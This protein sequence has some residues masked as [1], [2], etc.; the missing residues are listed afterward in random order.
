[1]AGFRVREAASRILPAIFLALF[2]VPR[3]LAA[4]EI[5]PGKIPADIMTE[6]LRA[7]NAPQPAAARACPV[8]F[9]ALSGWAGDDHAAAFFAFL[10]TCAPALDGKPAL[11]DALPPPDALRAACLAARNLAM[12]SARDARVFFERYFAAFDIRPETTE[13][14]PGTGFLT[15][16]FEPEIEASLTS[17]KGFSVPVLARP[18]DL[19][20]LKSGETHDGALDGL[21]AARRTD[22]GLAPYPDRAAI[23]DG[24]LAGQGLE[25]A[26]LR[27]FAELFI[28]QVQGSARLRLP[29]GR[30]SRLVYAGR[31]GHPYTSIGKRLVDSGE[32]ALAEMSLERLM[33]WLRAHP[34]RGRALMEENRSYVFFA[35]DDDAPIERGPIGGAGVP[36]TE[37]RSLAV[38]RTIWP[39]GLPVFIDV[40]P[41]V[42][43]GGRARIARLMIAQDTGSAIVGPARGDYFMGSGPAAGTRAGLVRDAS[44]FVVLWPRVEPAP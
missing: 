19:V 38:D 3:A 13:G 21:Q 40:A 11:R 24:A 6:T 7:G 10:K 35:R 1:M 16:Y 15:A 12:P 9:E 8:P 39:Y 4:P 25:I 22:S 27:D 41:L 44:R 29:D 34:E 32:I 23:W 42:P 18:A 30:L 33:R 17:G 26:W 43:T 2:L 31:N 28:T 5:C 37:E 14:H 20:T 36:L